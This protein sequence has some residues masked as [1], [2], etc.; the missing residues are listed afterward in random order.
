MSKNDIEQFYR[1]RFNQEPENDPIYFGEWKDRL[2]GLQKIGEIH[3]AMDYQSRRIW[4][5]VTGQKL[6]YMV[7]I[8]WKGPVYQLVNLQSGLDIGDSVDGRQEEVRK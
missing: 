7:L 1:D 2:T 6:G 3:P 4:G 5:K 8:G